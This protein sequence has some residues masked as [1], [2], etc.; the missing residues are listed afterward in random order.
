MTAAGWTR[1]GVSQMARK[2]VT[3]LG[4]GSVTGAGSGARVARARP[5]ISSTPTPST[6]TSHT[7]RRYFQSSASAPA[8]K[9]T[10][11]KEKTP[12]VRFNFNTSL[13]FTEEP[14]PD[15]VNYRR[16]TAAE[17]RSRKEPPKKVKM[18]VRDFID[19]S[20]YNPHYGYFSKNATIFVPPKGGYDF[21]QFKNETDFIEAV[22]ARY[23]S[24]YG[25]VVD[26][27]LG[28]QV[29]HTP[30]ELYKP[31]YAQALTSA[32][33]QSYKLNHYPYQDLIIY[34]LGAGNGSF[35]LDS[36]R[37][38]KQKHPE[39]FSRTKYRIIEISGQLAAR[40]RKR[41]KAAGLEDHVEIIESDF[42]KW[43]GG[44]P[45]PC[46]VVALE[47]LD[48]FAHDMIRYDVETLVPM[49][50][51][52]VI[53]AAGEF[54]L[55]YE[56]VNDPLLQRC[57]EYRSLLPPSP[58]TQPTVSKALSML[59]F[60]RSAMKNLPFSANLSKP[61]FIPSKAVLFLERLR[62]QLPQHRLLVADFSELP[63]AVKGRNGP[64]VQTRVRREMVPCET[65]L[66]KQGY[67]DIF[68]PTDFELL[69][70][71]YSLIMKSPPADLSLSPT[72]ESTNG[73]SDVL[74]NDFFSHSVRGFRRRQVGIY[75]QDEFVSKFGGEEIT[76]KL[77]TKDGANI[78]SGMYG[79]AK[80]MF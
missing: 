34:E 16:V 60:L 39:V 13:Y 24:E 31:Y 79:N 21:S 61:D 78:V 37:F 58:S 57:F 77:K 27:G 69:R 45:D 4:E 28:R 36:L 18:L 67:F 6:S 64:V 40:Q 5:A 41:A 55:L 38:I 51:V 30:T 47:V 29:W 43:G 1:R 26:G 59:P 73:R 76:D 22:A 7:P 19:D 65:F 20:L 49:Q 32:I 80:I 66:V 63:D 14:D 10:K 50:A 54:T 15:H 68:F 25:D 70:D 23:A 12:E 33:L 71:T 74:R 35:M 2:G 11:G 48:N 56:P 53:D 75:S 17:L 46:Y 62:A 3:G 52:V 8:P 9:D 44:G 72:G 42:F